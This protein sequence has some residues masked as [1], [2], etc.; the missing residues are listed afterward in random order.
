MKATDLPSWAWRDPA[1][2]AERREEMSCEGCLFR[3]VLV[4]DTPQCVKHRGRVGQGMY[5]CSDYRETK[6]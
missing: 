1:E 6:R 2:V 3:L 5:R 4:L